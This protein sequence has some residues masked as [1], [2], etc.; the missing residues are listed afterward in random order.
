V[1][2]QASPLTEAVNAIFFSGV[3]VYSIGAGAGL[4]AA[5]AG[6]GVA[7]NAGSHL[8][9]QALPF[10][11]IAFGLYVLVA[12]GLFLTGVVLQLLGRRGSPVTP[13]TL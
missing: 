10:T 12:L 6:E 5:L 8:A 9:Q 7:A 1:Y 4:P 3:A 2:R 11:G 13:Q